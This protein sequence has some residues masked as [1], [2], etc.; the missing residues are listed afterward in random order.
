MEAVVIVHIIVYRSNF[1]VVISSG[2]GAV[3][4]VKN[5]GN[6]GFKNMQ[7]RSL[8]AFI[9][10]L[11]SAF[12]YIVSHRCNC[13]FFKLEGIQEGLLH[14]IYQQFVVLVKQHNID[15]LGFRIVNT[16]VHNGCRN[17]R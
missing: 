2:T 5:S 3:L 7:K 16:V 15:I 8:E 10:V 11:L 13:V 6:L 9:A 1:F 17:K 4:F 14:D 12:K